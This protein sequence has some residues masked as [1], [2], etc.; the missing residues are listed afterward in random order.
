MS[1]GWECQR[2]YGAG[3]HEDDCSRSGPVTEEDS[4]RECR[5]CKRAGRVCLIDPFNTHE[6]CSV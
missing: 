6:T 1:D 3:Y 4:R 2:C 5:A